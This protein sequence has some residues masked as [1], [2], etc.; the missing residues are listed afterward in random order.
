MVLCFPLFGAKWEVG[1]SV[2]VQASSRC[3]WD[4][5][6]DNQRVHDLKLVLAPYKMTSLLLSQVKKFIDDNSHRV[7]DIKPEEIEKFV[8]PIKHVVCIGDI[9]IYSH[10]VSE[11]VVE[12]GLK[13][14]H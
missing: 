1:Y 4:W 14:T 8:L 3:Y 9:D 10:D 7:F 6:Q 5:E 2:D 11:A 13:S 12:W